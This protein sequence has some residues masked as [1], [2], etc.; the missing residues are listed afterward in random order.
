MPPRDVR[1]TSEPT[2]SVRRRRAGLSIGLSVALSL[3]LSLAAAAP[4][5]AAPHYLGSARSSVVN[6]TLINVPASPAP[7]DASYA[8]CIGSACYDMVVRAGA[9]TVEAQARSRGP[10]A[11]LGIATVETVAEAFGFGQMTL[12]ADTP[13]L[14][15]LVP[16]SVTMRLQGAFDVD[17]DALTSAWS[18]LR[19]F[20]SAGTSS[21]LLTEYAPG[22]DT[23]PDTT[24]Y[25]L[26]RSGPDTVTASLVLPL[27]TFNFSMLLTVDE[28]AF[29]QF[30][31]Y[32]VTSRAAAS[33]I[34]GAQVFTL[35]DGYHL[36]STDFAITDNRYCPRGCAATEIPEPMPAGLV[37][38]GVV[39]IAVARRRAAPGRPR[40][41][42]L[43]R[44]EDACHRRTSCVSAT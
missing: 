38:L 15:A 17:I 37:V 25:N 24:S 7:V 29:T 8:G 21:A 23:P 42:R 5:G 1:T 31:T 18:R 33:F 40:G 43:S 22:H 16:V 6:G 30:G 39:V 9:G 34:E 2:R 12:T 20:L 27:G 36:S 4:A 28:Q 44:Q 32:D 3:A 11:S 13:G 19:L 35:P 14:P 10:S 41:H 26:V